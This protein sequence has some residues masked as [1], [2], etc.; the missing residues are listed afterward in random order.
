MTFTALAYAYHSLNPQD[1][2]QNAILAVAAIAGLP[3]AL[4]LDAGILLG[5]FGVELRFVYF[6]L[7]TSDL[8][9]LTLSSLKTSRRRMAR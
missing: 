2:Y 4:Y 1:E 6:G 5:I 3:A 7:V 8:F 9:H